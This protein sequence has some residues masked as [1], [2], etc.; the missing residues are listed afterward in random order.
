MN[1]KSI[2]EAKLYS[3]T[4]KT[5]TTQSQGSESMSFL[6]FHSN[7]CSPTSFNQASPK[8]P[9]TPLLLRH[10]LYRSYSLGWTSLQSS[11]VQVLQPAPKPLRNN[12]AASALA[13][14]FASQAPTLRSAFSRRAYS[15]YSICFAW[16]CHHF[17]STINSRFSWQENPQSRPFLVATFTHSQRT[18]KAA[19]DVGIYVFQF[20]DEAGSAA[21]TTSSDLWQVLQSVLLPISLTNGSKQKLRLAFERTKIT[22]SASPRAVL[23][24]YWKTAWITQ[25]PLIPWGTIWWSSCLSSCCLC[26]ERSSWRCRSRCSQ[27]RWNRLC[28]WNNVFTRSISLLLKICSPVLDC[29][30]QMILYHWCLT[31]HSA[32]VMKCSTTLSRLCVNPLSTHTWVEGSGNALRGVDLGVNLGFIAT[33]K[34]GSWRYGNMGY[35][36]RRCE[37]RGVRL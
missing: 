10:L 28:R 4:L 25:V 9:N 37:L 21:A 12:H 5:Q 15:M 3:S 6:I 30:N 8:R 32:W 36:T 22:I 23:L 19:T 31:V 20:L 14:L 35:E 26:C 18:E 29:V 16:G 13:T 24:N 2:L 7:F 34:Y 1:D 27:Y 11:K 33:K 17:H